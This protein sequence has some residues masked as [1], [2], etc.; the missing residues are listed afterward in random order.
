MLKFSKI[1]FSFS[2]LWCRR[3][4]RWEYN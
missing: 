4:N 1:L 3:S 2:R